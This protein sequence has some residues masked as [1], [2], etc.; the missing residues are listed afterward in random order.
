VFGIRGEGFATHHQLM[1]AAACLFIFF[2][3]FI[4]FLLMLQTNMASNE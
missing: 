3:D 4:L 2:S 1:T